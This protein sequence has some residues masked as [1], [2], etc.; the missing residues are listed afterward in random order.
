VAVVALGRVPITNQELNFASLQSILARRRDEHTFAVRMHEDAIR[1]EELLDTECGRAYRVWA[2]GENYSTFVVNGETATA[3]RYH[4][5][6]NDDS[7][8]NA[9][10]LYRPE[11]SP[12][13]SVTHACGEQAYMCG[14][15]TQHHRSASSSEQSVKVLVKVHK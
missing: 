5:L 4:V 7:Y 6:T 8:K 13:Q 2:D 14:H 15:C 3:T 10:R 12:Q 9:K 1:A 11:L